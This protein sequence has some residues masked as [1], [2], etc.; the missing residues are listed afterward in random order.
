MPQIIDP[1]T[2]TPLDFAEVIARIEERGV[3]LANPDA[4]PDY[5]ALLAGLSANREFLADRVMA[6]LKASY[7]RQLDDNRYSAQVFLLHRSGRRFFLRANLWPAARDYAYVTSGPAAFSYEVPHNHNFSF[8]TVGHLGPGYVSDYYEYDAEAVDGRLD[9]PLNL[10]F[11]ERSCLSEG[12]V[13]L[14]RAHR[15]IHSQLP[16]DSLSISLNIMEE[17][18]AVPWRDQYIVD[19]EHG[20]I[21]KRPTLTQG[22]MLLRCAVHFCDEGV[23]LADQFAKRHPVPRVRANAIAALA[24]VAEGDGRTATLERGLID[25][26]ARVRDDCARWLGEGATEYR[27]MSQ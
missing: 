19:L 4:L 20:T 22:E 25:G 2:A 16:P 3:D 13:Q 1:G 9:E 17:G 8:L 5:A 26:D 6:E 7:D 10:S 18:E 27:A 11:V 24:A 12:K 21:A 14:Y 15:D 23:D